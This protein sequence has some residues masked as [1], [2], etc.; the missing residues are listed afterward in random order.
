MSCSIEYNGQIYTPDEFKQYISD[1]FVDFAAFAS[2]KENKV[3]YVFRSVKLLL[4]DKALKAFKYV[5]DGVW[6][7]EKALLELQIP[8]AQRNL[9]LSIG[10]TEREDIIIELLSNYSYSVQINTAL[11]NENIYYTVDREFNPDENSYDIIYNV[12]NS[13]NEVIRTFYNKIEAEK[14]IQKLNEP[15]QIYL[16]LTVPGGTNGSYIEANIETPMIVPSIQ[17]H[18]EFKTENTIG[19]G[20]WDEK[21]QYTD[22]D[23]DFLIDT[24]QKSGQLEINCK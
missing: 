10:K 22:K 20:R 8:T 24:L 17:S 5:K 23:I 7:L 1:N 12:R 13:E 14:R 2:K 3:D 19:W 16:N 11:S 21:M 15:T 18:A 4:S 9:I 6:N